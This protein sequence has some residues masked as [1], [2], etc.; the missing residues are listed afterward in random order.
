MLFYAQIVLIFAVFAL[1]LHNSKLCFHRVYPSRDHFCKDFFSSFIFWKL[2][3]NLQS[4]NK[5][6]TWWF[7]N[8]WRILLVVLCDIVVHFT[9]LVLFGAIYTSIYHAYSGAV[10]GFCAIYVLCIFCAIIG[11]API[12]MSFVKMSAPKYCGQFVH[13]KCRNHFGDLW[14]FWP[15]F[16]S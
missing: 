13:K 15:K 7:L 2:H 10:C 4:A 8:I 16:R 14:Y 3:L 5:W 11:S 9:H 6:S 1:F 12:F